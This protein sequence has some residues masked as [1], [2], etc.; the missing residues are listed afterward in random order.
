MENLQTLQAKL[1]AINAQIESAKTAE[2]VFKKLQNTK[3]H[4]RTAHKYY[5]LQALYVQTTQTNLKG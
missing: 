3:L 5:D 1:D 4:A 2:K